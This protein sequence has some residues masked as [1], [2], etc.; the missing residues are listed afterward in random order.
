MWDDAISA[1]RAELLKF[2][3]DLKMHIRLRRISTD[4][5]SV[6][7]VLDYIRY[8]GEYL[9]LDNLDAARFALENAKGE[10]RDVLGLRFA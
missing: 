2:I 5:S 10:A 4:E 7:N 8:A 3:R 9:R 1:Q 6:Q